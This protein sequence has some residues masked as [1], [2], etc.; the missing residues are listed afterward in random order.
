MTTTRHY[1]PNSLVLAP[2]LAYLT[3]ERPPT[4]EAEAHRLEQLRQLIEAA[5]DTADLRA[6]AEL[7]REVMGAGYTIHSGSSHT[8]LKR[9]DQPGRLAII[10]DRHTTAYRD[11]NAPARQGNVQVYLDRITEPDGRELIRLSAP[12]L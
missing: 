5:P 11:Y 8:W 4:D 3:V 9:D 2:Q 10:A 12:P 6:F 7:A 1:A